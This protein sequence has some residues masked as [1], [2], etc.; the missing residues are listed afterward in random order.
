MKKL[1]ILLIVPM[2]LAL[3]SCVP[4][5]TDVEESPDLPLASPTKKLISI[6]GDDN[7]FLPTSSA[8]DME[9]LIEKA[10][11]DLAQR[12]G[13]SV[14]SISVATVIGQEF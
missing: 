13:I 14:D 12:L 6:R 2:S 1:W 4:S 9:G 11:E 5:Q 8:S 7:P 10:K 3:T